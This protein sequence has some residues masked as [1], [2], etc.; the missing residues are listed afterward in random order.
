MTRQVVSTPNAPSAVGPYSQGIIAN[1]FV[2]TAGQGGLNPATK[3]L[4]D[5]ISEQTL[6][7]LENIR[8]I[9]EAAG[10]NMGNVVKTTV[11][12][13]NIND[14][15]AMNAVYSTFFPA[16][17]PARATIQAAALPMG[18]L[19]QIDAVATLEA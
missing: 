14:F 19:V 4:S 17:P 15:A 2:F 6:Q 1:G 8:A 11:Y 12:L 7:T 5:G 18:M 10:T 13:A 9:L 3:A 16:N